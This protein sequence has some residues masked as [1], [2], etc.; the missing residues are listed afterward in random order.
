MPKLLSKHKR[1]LKEIYEEFIGPDTLD[2]DFL[3]KIV[4][5]YLDDKLDDFDK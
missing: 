5:S 3:S 1:A 2:P 4:S